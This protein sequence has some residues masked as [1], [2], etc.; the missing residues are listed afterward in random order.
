MTERN[1]KTAHM[2]YLPTYLYNDIVY[3]QLSILNVVIT[4]IIA[5]YFIKCLPPPVAD[6]NI[7]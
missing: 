7:D 6:K 1:N 2:Y 3:R 4:N 5:L